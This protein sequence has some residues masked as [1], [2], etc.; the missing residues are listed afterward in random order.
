MSNL[1]KYWACRKRILLLCYAAWCVCVC[2][3]NYKGR[4]GTLVIPVRVRD[5]ITCISN[6]T[7]ILPHP[8]CQVWCCL[9][10]AHWTWGLRAS[11]L[12]LLPSLQKPP[13]RCWSPLQKSLWHRWYHSAQ[14]DSELP[15]AE[16]PDGHLG[17]TCFLAGESGIVYRLILWMH[18][19]RSGK[20]FSHGREGRDTIAVTRGRVL[21]K[22][23]DRT[24]EGSRL[25]MRCHLSWRWERAGES[26]SW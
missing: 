7:P 9:C 25:E 12:T 16:P 26:R 19:L 23:Q 21:G 13:P 1:Q 5:N 18:L 8:C 15:L 11:S 20:E 24:G 22:Q 4:T 6:H 14:P 2:V 17:Q 3:C 10:F